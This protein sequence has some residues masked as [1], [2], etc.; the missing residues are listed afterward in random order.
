MENARLIVSYPPYIRND[1]NIEKIMY[2]VVLALLPA[3]AVSVRFFGFRALN[4]VFVCVASSMFFEYLVNKLRKQDYTFL[5][6]SAVVTGVLL[7]LNLPA[8]LPYWMVVLGAFIAIVVVKQLF[9]GLGCNIFNPALAAR[10]FLL[11]SFPA[12]MTSWPLPFSVDM[13][14]AASPLGLLKTEGLKAVSSITLW[15][16]FAGKIGGSLGETS[17]LALLLGASILFWKK[18][19]TWVIPFAFVGSVFVFTAIFHWVDPLKYASP[20]FH[21]VTGGLLLGALFMATDMVTS[22]VSRRGQWIF[23]MGC[24]LLT[25]VIRLFG[26]YPEGVS[27]AILIMNA[28]VPLLDRWDEYSY[29]KKRRLVK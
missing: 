12:A 22:P 3:V 6:G 9:G 13:Q 4:V 29:S 23:G 5:D 11:I 17:G 24:G 25:G 7:A 1:E 14:T 8:N 19:I 21:M 15:Q 16:A 10:V 26:G 27:F 2:T 28:F 20:M 18:Y